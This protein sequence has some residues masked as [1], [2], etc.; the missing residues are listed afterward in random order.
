MIGLWR[1]T[2]L[3]APL[4]KGGASRT[5]DVMPVGKLLGLAWMTAAQFDVGSGTHV[6][7]QFRGVTP[8]D[9]HSS[10]DPFDHVHDRNR[11]ICCLKQLLPNSPHGAFGTLC[12]PV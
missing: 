12:G 11:A 1:I 7:V 2:S 5:G 6:A 10:I 3:L 8:F 9:A 4:H